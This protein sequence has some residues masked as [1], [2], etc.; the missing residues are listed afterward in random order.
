MPTIP[1]RRLLAEVKHGLRDYPVT[2]IFGPR[3]CGKTTLAR[4]AAKEFKAHYFDL[5]SP[6][7]LRA[8]QDPAAAL[9]PLKGLVVLDEAQRLPAL[10]ELL[11]VLADRRPR[12]ARFLVLGSASPQIVKGISES[13]AGRVRHV[14]AGGLELGDLPAARWP[15]L[16]LRGGFPGSLLALSEGASLQWRE[17]FIRTFIE[18]DMGSFELRLPPMQIRRFWGMVAHYHGGI[19]N[20]SELGTSLGI[21][22]PTARRLLDLMTGAFV[23]RQLPPYYANVGKRIVK[24][25]KVYVRDSGVFHSLMGI[26]GQTALASNPKLGASWEGFGVE[27]ILT[28]T[29]E[30]GAFFWA[31][32][33]GPELDLLLEAKGERWGFEFKS[34]S[35]PDLTHSMRAAQEALGLRHLWV[36]HPGPRSYPMRDGISALC[37]AD[38]KPA[39]K[40]A[41]LMKL[42]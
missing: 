3:Q 40:S 6:S 23:M 33:N 9:G 4:V 14:D 27:Q 12:K 28:L 18:R 35:A 19:F 10:F 5:E 22:H 41:G 37:L 32:H 2:A 38:L 25:P 21:S 20:S 1:R 16:W 42:A 26:D 17:G 31:V 36:V 39:L 7:D 29:G 11:R 8:L 13:L 15:R 24:S 34:H 30:R